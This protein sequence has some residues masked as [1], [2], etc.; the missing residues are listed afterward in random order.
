MT[1]IKTGARVFLAE[2]GCVVA[3]DLFEVHD[4][5][6][7][8]ANEKALE[9]ANHLPGAHWTHRAFVAMPGQQA[10]NRPDIGVFVIERAMIEVNP[11]GQD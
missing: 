11:D 5:I 6:V 4:C 8:R 2:Y 1:C 7:I 3:A 10:F 9:T